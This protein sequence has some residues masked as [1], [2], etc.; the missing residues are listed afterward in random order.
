MKIGSPGVN[1][2]QLEVILCIMRL[3]EDCP[4]VLKNGFFPPHTVVFLLGTLV[5]NLSQ[6]RLNHYVAQKYG[7]CQDN[8]IAD[9]FIWKLNFSSP[10]KF[11]A[12][13]GSPLIDSPFLAQQRRPPLPEILQAREQLA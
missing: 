7:D 11:R 12:L 13:W 5:M 9:G 4:L 8:G 1:P 2:G 3:D 6:Q 10:F